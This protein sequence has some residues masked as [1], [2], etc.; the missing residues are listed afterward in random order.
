MRVAVLGA[1]GVIGQ[2]LLPLLSEQHAVVAV[3][4]RPRSGGDGIR[5]VVADA[6]SGVGV[7][8]ALEGADV[9]YHLV[10]SL[11]GRDFET[12]D[13][14]AAGNV[15]REAARAGLKQLIYLGGL[16]G[17]DPDASPHLRSR[18]ETG[19]R[20][21]ADGVP[22]TTLRAAMVV[23]RGSAAFETILGLVKRLPVMIT[24]SWVST[25]TQPIALE[26]VARY[27]AGVC[28]NDDAIGEE[29]D[30]GG[31]EVMTYRQMIERIA[32]LLGRRPRFIEVPVL[33]PA[34]SALWLELVTPVN[35]AVARPLVE[36][37]RSATVAHDERL[38]KLLPF[39]LTSFDDAARRALGS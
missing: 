16:G 2:A 11:G 30:I 33:T 29:F 22:V 14:Q 21:G 8:E 31:P 4:R 7:A 26:D 6:A 19:E 5:W 10:H 39:E 28:G 3:S 23:G 37:L 27:L 32:A 25:P 24:P 12:Q 17:D 20:L 18:R 38:R 1:T 36:G 35:A 15:S 13:R 34:L 9:A